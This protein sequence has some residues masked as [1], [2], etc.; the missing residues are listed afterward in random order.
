MMKL[1]TLTLS[2]LAVLALAACTKTEEKNETAVPIEVQNASN[3]ELQQAVVDRDELLSLVTQINNDVVK[4]KEM[5][6]LISINGTETP[7]KRTQL[8]NDMEAIKASLAEKQSRLEELESRLKSSNLYNEKLES[9]ISSLKTQIEQQS[10]EIASLN[11]RLGEANEVIRQQS[12]TIDTL[13]TTVSERNTQLAASQQTNIDLT[14]DLNRCYY[15]VG[16]E[17]TLKEQKIIEKSFLR[18][19][20]ILP[21][22]FNQSYFTEADKSKL[23]EINLY[24]KKAEVM[25]QQPKDSYELVDGDNGMKV[26]KIT[27]PDKFWN[28]SNFLVVKVN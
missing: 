10:A 20:K 2:A 13:T 8:L 24:A 21:S 18:K 26:L 27:N 11:A 6:G 22:D 4:I 16:S 28:V 17:K 15:A 5:E 12:A 7:N 1:K 23:T 25:T 9:T 19:T 14:N 3:E